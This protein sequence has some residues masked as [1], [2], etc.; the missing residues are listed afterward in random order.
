MGDFD[1][2]EFE[3]LGI[4]LSVPKRGRKLGS[5][6]VDLKGDSGR[7]KKKKAGGEGGF[8]GGG[9]TDSGLDRLNRIAAKASEV[10]VKVSS[11][12]AGFKQMR[13]HLNYIT[14]N[15][16]LTGESPN[17]EVV[18][19]QEVNTLADQWW[20]QRG[21]SRGKH[22]A[23][24]K[25]TVNV[26]LSMPPGTDRDKFLSGARIFVERTF[27]NHDYLMVEHRDT[28]HPHVHVAVRSVGIDRT[29]LQH[30]K[31]DLQRWREDL[32]FQLRAQ[33]IT[34]EATPRR[35]RGVVEKPKSQA[36]RHLN[37]R[38]ASL[39]ERSKIEEAVRS[40]TRSVDAGEKPW[41]MATRK[42]QA[43]IRTNWNKL[44]DR[45]ENE[46]QGGG[47]AVAIRSFVAQMG[48]VETERQRIQKEVGK[49]IHARNNARPTGPAGQGGRDDQE[50]DR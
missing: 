32:A 28:D 23:G 17:G 43:E 42:R 7:A 5:D 45:L 2:K 30:K 4:V 12:S 21:E 25:D 41:E 46:G 1:P 31:P 49:A 44:A 40:I 48:P 37:M 39:V 33:G 14:R 15:G 8:S 29:R 11:Q 50:Q 20:T 26:I 16:E 9:G 19:R 34:A 13:E 38:G 6:P 27:E 24:T 18:G 35:T 36:I 47:I 22:R 3:R 10:M